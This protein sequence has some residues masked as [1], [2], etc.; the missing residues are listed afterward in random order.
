MRDS[1]KAF[2]LKLRLWE[3]QMRRAANIGEDLLHSL[4]RDD[5]K[6]LFPGPANFLRRR[7]IWLVVNAERWRLLPKFY[8]H[9]PLETVTFQMRSPTLRC[10]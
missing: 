8:I 4:S 9:H 1:V 6:D 3:G 7:A 10:L 5:I 2:E